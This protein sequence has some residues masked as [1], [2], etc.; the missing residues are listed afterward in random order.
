MKKV[1]RAPSRVL[2]RWLNFKGKAIRSLQGQAKFV[3]RDNQYHEL[4]LS[5]YDNMLSITTFLGNKSS[6]W[7]HWLIAAPAFMHRQ[8]LFSP[9]GRPGRRDR[10]K[11]RKSSQPSRQPWG[12]WRDLTSPL[13]ETLARHEWGDGEMGKESSGDCAVK[14]SSGDCAVKESSGDCAVKESSG[15]CAVKETSGDC[16]V[17]ESSGENKEKEHW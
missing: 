7:W 14:E 6:I 17:K 10:S 1:N 15:D 4:Y 3:T 16:A 5:L 8:A 13:K 11:R 2:A 12:S 9:A